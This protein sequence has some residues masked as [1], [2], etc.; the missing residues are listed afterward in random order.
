MTGRWQ[1]G[2]SRI[3]DSGSRC[4]RTYTA[5]LNM[6]NRC[7]NPQKKDSHVYMDIGYDPRWDAFE[8][9]LSDMG[10]CPDGLTL[11]RKDNNFGYSKNNCCWATREEQSRNRCS[12]KLNAEKAREIKKLLVEGLSD[13]S[14]AER[15]GV[16]S[17]VIGA[18][19]RG[20]NWVSA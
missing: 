19:R 11:E 8:N 4:S 20:K 15:F 9:F 2:H 16:S 7:C 13:R 18:I 12:V 6:K 3:S 10:E 5:W 14:I 1:H 17:Q